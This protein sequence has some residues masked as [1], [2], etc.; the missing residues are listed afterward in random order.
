M[1]D[2]V[3][4][5]LQ[6][7]VTNA[8]IGTALETYLGMDP[9]TVHQY[10]NDFDVYESGDWTVTN[11]STHATNG[12]TAGNGGILSMANSSTS[13]DL[14]QLTLV[15]A[16]F[17]FV[18]GLQAWFKARFQVSNATNSGLVVGLQNLNTNAF[19]ATDGVWFQKSET[20]TTLN[21]IVSASSTAT[22]SS[23]GLTMA[24]TTYVDVGFYYDGGTSGVLQ[25]YA[26]GTPVGSVST[27]NLPASTT[28][29]A[30]TIALEN[31]TAAANT[32]LVDYVLAAVE[33]ESPS[34]ILGS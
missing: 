33:R 15:V 12:L 23:W 11:T 4:T 17:A 8:V 30:L 31:G 28:N 20:S 22:T 27:T 19:A 3:T 14:D 5:L 10:F 25:L 7:G 6:G 24:N 26:N 13:A 9:S 34:Q 32:L 2:R 1:P 29:L 16:S 21:A 18:P